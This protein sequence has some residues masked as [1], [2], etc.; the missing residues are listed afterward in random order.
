M[1]RIFC[2]GNNCLNNTNTTTTTTTNNNNNNSNI[3]D[4]FLSRLQLFSYYSFCCR[5]C[6]RCCCRCCCFC[7]GIRQCFV[8]FDNI[9]TDFSE[10]PES[11]PKSNDPSKFVCFTNVPKPVRLAQGYSHKTR[12]LNSVIIILVFQELFLY[13]FMLFVCNHV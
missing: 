8:Q 3:E 10:T 7:K 12:K 4:Y 11:D 6:Y 13:Y 1:T 9:L 2:Q 5:C